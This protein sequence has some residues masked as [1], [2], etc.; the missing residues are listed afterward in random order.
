MIEL[1]N[2]KE[3]TGC[4][5]CAFIC[6][7]KCINM[8]EDNMG[9]IYP[10][11]ISEKCIQCKQCQKICPILNPA[12]L[13]FPRDV[14][15]AR[16][17]DEQIRKTSASGGLATELYRQAYK[18]NYKIVGAKQNDDFSVSLEF[19]KDKKYIE[20]FRNSK[21]VFSSA[22][23]LFPQ[24]KEILKE[25]QKV[26]V[27]GLPCQIAAIRKIFKDNENLRLVDIVC[28]GTTPLKYL[29]EHINFLENKYNKKAKRMSFRDPSLGTET[30]TLTLY[31]FQ[32]VRF[33]NLNTKH[34]DS[35]QWG[36]HR[37]ITYR[38]NCYHCHFAQNKRTGDLSLSDYPRLG[39][40]TPYPYSKENI[41][42]VLVN[43]LKGENLI[44]E[45]IDSRAITAY[46]RPIEEAI[47]GN[48]QLR[49]PTPI[50]QARIS[51][52]RNM[53]KYNWDFEKS[54]KSIAQKGLL[55]QKVKYIL[56]IPY[57]ITSKLHRIIKKYFK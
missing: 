50:S 21:Y 30:F 17:N 15:A 49:R 22:Y 32:N 41:S 29:L 37:G 25:E 19:A 35:Y 16:S 40:N 18:N 6:P 44:K 9:V 4:G 33:C 42:C 55:K 23:G 13:F 10:Q 47:N 5:A 31:D 11:I 45:L 20:Y 46:R 27:I 3:C 2:K 56:N 57:R 28:H 26:L 8:Q 12:D 54:M 53:Y 52:L 38:E 39:L 36:Y 34:G 14:Y 48:P 43:N 7:Q 1:A 51:F 24:L